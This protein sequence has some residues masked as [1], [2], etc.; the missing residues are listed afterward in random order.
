MPASNPSA[1]I[2]LQDERKNRYGY[3]ATYILLLYHFSRPSTFLHESA[4]V[5]TFIARNTSKALAPLRIAALPGF[6]CWQAVPLARTGCNPTAALIAIN[7]DT[8]AQRLSASP[9]RPTLAQGL[10]Q[11]HSGRS[12]SAP[13]RKLERVDR[14]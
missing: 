2:F 13:A 5:A 1:V 8:I 10:L 6:W 4:A 7:V 9:A 12:T 3:W 11:S 14:S